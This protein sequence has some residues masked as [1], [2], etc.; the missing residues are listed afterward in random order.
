MS[1]HARGTYL[2]QDGGRFRL[3]ERDG[4]R[5]VPADFK[6]TAFQSAAQTYAYTHIFGIQDDRHLLPEAALVA[7]GE[8]MTKIPYDPA[9]QSAIPA[10]YTYLG[11]F[12][13]HDITLMTADGTQR[14]KPLNERTPALDLDSVLPSLRPANT[15]AGCRNS[16]PL[17]LGCTSGDLDLAEDLPRD[18]VGS[19][20]AGKP[21][22]ADPR[23]D[24]FL[25]LAQCHVTLIKFYNAVARSQG[26]NPPHDDAWWANVRRIWI[27]HFQ[28]V[29]LHDYLPRL[30]DPAT[31]KDVMQN[32]RKIVRTHVKAGNEA[33]L[34]AEFAGAVARFGHSMI[35]DTYTNWNRLLEFRKVTLA[36]FMRFSYANS[37]DT[38]EEHSFRLLV[39]WVT[40]WLRL[41][42]FTG[43]QY[44]GLA[45]P[46][47][48]AAPIDP[49][50]AP[51]LAKLPECMRAD[52]CKGYPHPDNTFPLQVQT[53]KRGLDLKLAS[54]QQAITA[55]NKVLPVPIPALP[56]GQ[57]TGGDANIAA[58]FQR[59]PRLNEATPL[60]YYTL[61]EA[62]H[63]ARGQ[64]LG[65][66]GSRILM[67]T[68][69]AA[70]EASSDSIL[71]HPGWRPAFPSANATHFSMPDLI[72]MAGHPNPL[73]P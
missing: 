49:S 69:H 29:V 56:A 3:F 22:I 62:A 50:L 39:M 44:G 45:V 46:P 57:L 59:Y 4:E 1:R 7:L 47:L 73:A 16:R 20:H 6:A 71:D 21:R 2:V 5:S 27:E 11:Q 70:I 30:V 28:S 51:S 40:N 36:D 9:A 37:T 35:R 23:N 33:W 38:L 67:E 14:D 48:T 10:G 31:Y 58:V 13:F 54:A 17:P 19:P 63:F 66:L 34:P 53:L 12:I 8:A 43:T 25:P 60:W 18:P 32:G 42:D 41:F 72:A 61:R 26:Y 24:D 52:I 55:L 64:H 15:R 68:I 65:P